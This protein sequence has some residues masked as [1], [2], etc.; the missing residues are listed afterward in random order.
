[1]KRKA[2]SLAKLPAWAAA[3][4]SKKPTSG[5]PALAPQWMAQPVSEEPSPPPQPDFELPPEVWTLILSFCQLSC[6]TQCLRLL[7]V[8]QQWTPLLDP[9]L[10]PIYHDMM[11]PAH[12]A[13]CL[14]L[15]KLGDALHVMRV[16]LYHFLG[17]NIGELRRIGDLV[18]QATKP[19]QVFQALDTET[20]RFEERQ[21][22][23][24]PHS[25]AVWVDL[26]YPLH[27]AR[28]NAR[29]LWVHN[30]MG[31]FRME[32]GRSDISTGNTEI[33]D[34]FELDENQKPRCLLDR[35]GLMAIE[36]PS[37]FGLMQDARKAAEKLED[38]EMRQ[39]YLM[40][41]DSRQNDNRRRAVA[42]GLLRDRYKPMKPKADTMMQNC[43]IP[44]EHKDVL[45][46][47]REPT[48][49][50]IFSRNLPRMWRHDAYWSREEKCKAIA[51]KLFVEKNRA[52]GKLLQRFYARFKPVIRI[53][54]TVD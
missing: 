22:R 42:Y 41:L 25:A 24:Q 15:N 11:Q 8:C 12:L 51:F 35:P 7:A 33:G 48:Y 3:R 13:P 2:E 31:L 20:G 34:I 19:W 50:H 53:D 37:A 16:E 40:A 49:Q 29:M 5:E 36:L 30:N 14:G 38:E 10:R 27:L 45:T 43:V 32:Y 1:M 28:L 46:K 9:L 17:R 39:A 4:M 6:P 18:Y 21:I 23:P 26:L 44:R 52:N 47:P 54:C